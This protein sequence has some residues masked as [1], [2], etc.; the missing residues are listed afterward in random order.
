MELRRQFTLLPA[1]E[2]FLVQYG[3]PWETISDGSQWVLIYDFPTHN[4]YNPAKTSIAVRLETGY[5]QAHLDMVYVYPALARKDGKTIPQ[6][7]VKQPLDGK[8]WQR[9]SRHRTAANP[10][11]PG[12]DSLETHVYLIEDWFVREFEK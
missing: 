4:G 8:E 10:W 2:A 5:P 9:W 12:E 6:T 7:Q 1:D 3:L 11:Q